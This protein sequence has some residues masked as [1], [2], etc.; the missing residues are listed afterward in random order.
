MQSVWRRRHLA[1]GMLHCARGQS[2]MGAGARLPW[3]SAG[4]CVPA[5]AHALTILQAAESCAA[6][7][8]LVLRRQKLSFTR[9][10]CSRGMAGVEGGA[11]CALLDSY[12]NLQRA[13]RSAHVAL[14][15]FRSLRPRFAQQT[16]CALRDPSG[17]GR[18]QPALK[19]GSA[20]RRPSRQDLHAP[21][22]RMT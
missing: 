11:P 4:T 2:N 18:C 22:H 16:G 3:L 6:A 19:P 10:G 7:G 17:P 8:G 20:V 15:A 13:W 9:C 21:A 12:E 1:W 14:P 5:S